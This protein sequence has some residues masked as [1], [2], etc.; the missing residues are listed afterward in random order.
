MP[1][2]QSTET[3]LALIEQGQIIS[4]EQ[5]REVIA[6][7]NVMDKKLDER[8]CTLH[9]ARMLQIDQDLKDIKCKVDSVVTK[10]ATWSGAVGVLAFLAGKVF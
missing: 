7:L 9:S 1:P 8:Q 6:K 2:E 4:A 3:R 10:L 5:H